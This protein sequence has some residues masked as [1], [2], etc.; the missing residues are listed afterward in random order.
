[1]VM[2]G[3]MRELMVAVDTLGRT[4]DWGLPEVIVTAVVV[5]IREADSGM[6]ARM[7]VRMGATGFSALPIRLVG[8]ARLSRT[9]FRTFRNSG[10]ML[11][12]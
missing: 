6:A 9:R 3:R 12:L 4:L 1:M 7:G 5:F 10:V 8:N 11:A 2:P